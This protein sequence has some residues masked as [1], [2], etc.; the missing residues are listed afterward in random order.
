MALSHY[1]RKYADQP[2]NEIQRRV[3]TKAEELKEIFEHVSLASNNDTVYV[4]VLGCGDKRFIKAH[5]TLFEQ[6]THKQIE[7]VTFDITVE[8]LLGEE[9]VVQH[10]CTLPL[11]NVPYDIIYAHVLL[12][13]IETEKQWD[14]LMNSYNALSPRGIAIHV[15]DNEEIESKDAILPN[16]QYAVPLQRWKDKLKKEKIEYKGI[17]VK[18]GLVLVLLAKHE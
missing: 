6:I 5:K 14:L 12:K 10:D 7:L 1:H 13:F 15:L 3:D 18:Y 11:P 4:A 8:H 17:P 2:D 9:N 16:G